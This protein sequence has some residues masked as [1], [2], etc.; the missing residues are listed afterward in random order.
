MST[1]GDGG[2]GLFLL[3]DCLG[4]ARNDNAPLDTAP[5]VLSRGC[6]SATPKNPEPL[7]CLVPRPKALTLVLTWAEA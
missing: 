3:V 5:C 1:D 7:R 6:V 2:S 4:R